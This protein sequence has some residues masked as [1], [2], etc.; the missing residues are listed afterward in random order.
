MK[1][2]EIQNSKIVFFGDSI[3]DSLKWFNEKYPYGMGFVSMLTSLLHTSYQTDKPIIYNEG[4]GG[5]KTENLLSRIEKDVIEKNPDIVFLLI[6]INDVWHPVEAKNEPN[7]DGIFNR[8]NKIIDR[9]QETSRLIILTPFLFPTDEFF[10]NL[11]PYFT[12]LRKR[13]L[14]LLKKRKLE[15]IDI[16]EK[17]KKVADTINHQY[18]TADSVHPTSVGHAIISQEILYYLYE[19]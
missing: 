2:E 10:T 1:I 18:V 8:L 14:D 12:E 16:Y 13:Y 3:T 6:G 17:L 11:M 19:H 9:I 7:Y 15:Y 5:D 4:I